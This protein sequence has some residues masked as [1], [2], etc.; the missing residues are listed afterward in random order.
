MNRNT[1]I[2]T[3]VCYCFRDRLFDP[4]VSIS[5]E[6]KIFGWIKFLNCFDKSNISLLNE[7]QKRKTTAHIFFSN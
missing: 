7:I 1:N 6:F 5:R 4:S 2:F 3:K